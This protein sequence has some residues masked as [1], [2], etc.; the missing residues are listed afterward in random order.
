MLL[1]LAGL[2][3]T[4]KSTLAREVGQR[5]GGAVLGKDAIRAALFGDNV[6]YSSEQ[7]DFVFEVMLQTAAWIV[8]KDHRRPVIIDGR[9]FACAAQLERVKTFAK[10]IAVDLLVAECVCS[11]QT[12]RQRIEA[13]L[14]R[15]AHVA[16]N[17]TFD[18]YQEIKRRLEPI[19]EPK[20]VVNTDAPLEDCVLSVLRELR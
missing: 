4:G 12:A 17:R 8:A 11:E 18:L 2:P 16:G 1:V 10:K 6:D 5:T 13:D 9:V 19:P 7:D 15:G 14:A 20:L 3:G